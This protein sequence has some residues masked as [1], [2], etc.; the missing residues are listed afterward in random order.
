MG[1]EVFGRGQYNETAPA[2]IA[3]AG[4]GF[5][6]SE[7]SYDIN[8]TG[9]VANA[10]A[11][12]H[13]L[14]RAGSHRRNQLG[15]A[16]RVSAGAVGLG[17][18]RLSQ[19]PARA[20]AVL[21]GEQPEPHPA[22]HDLCGRQRPAEHAEH[23]HR[24]GPGFPWLA[25][26]DT[27][28]ISVNLTHL[29]GKHNMK[30]GFFYE[31]TGGPARCRATPAPTTSTPTR[32]IRSTPTSGGRTRC[33]GTSTPTPRTT[34]TPR[35]MPRF[36]QPEFFVQDN[37][38]VNRK[39]TLDLGVRFSHI[40]VVYERGRDIGWFD[41]SAW[42]A[43]KAVKLWQPH[44][45]NGVFPCT[46]ANRVALNPLTGEQRPSPVDRRD[47]RRIGRHQQR[48]GLWQGD[49]RHVPQ[50][51]HQDRAASRVRLGRLRGRQD[52]GPR[53]VRHQL[54]PPRRRP[55]RRVHRGHQPDGE[56]AV[57]HDRRSLQCAVA[58]EPAGRAP[59]SR[60]R[61]GRSRVHSWSVGVQREL[62]WRLLADVAYVGN[63]VRNAFAVNA[64]QSYTNQLNDPDPRLLA[65]PTPDM[66][67]R[68][69]GNVLPTNLIRPNYP[70]RG[71]DHPARLPGRAVP[72]LQRDPVG[73]PPPA[74]R[75][76][77]LGGELHGSVTEQYTGY[78]WYRTSEDNETRNSHKNGSRPHNLKV[79]YN[80]MMPG[81][82]QA[83]GQ[84]RHRRRRVRRLAVVGD[85]D[86]PGRHLSKFHL[87]LLGRG[88]RT[89]RP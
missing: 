1:K 55:V 61:R 19:P 73:S 22:G 56:P 33:S 24:P 48:H 54:Q 41:P 65:N 39:L 60:T 29:R 44:C 69:T 51:R 49:P 6:W 3:G 18:P 21:P 5:P 72:Q 7:G 46:G 85:L 34:T 67:D 11:H 8:T 40:G 28:N 10:H 81:L 87:Q 88:A 20:P 37:W 71:G 23:Q 50:R 59:S 35:S 4:M 79:T 32:P 58:R 26:N 2:L 70:G 13:R 82:E 30:T 17:C 36:N 14:D 52:R 31:R 9:Y 63:T 15:G 27:H 64:G 25:T 47:R 12:V 84:Q 53:R 66:I 57:D 38:R 77:R 78:D 86:L 42:N 16:G 80:W 83:H 45:A 43:A 89:P 74:R 62:P 75:R 76:A 68:T